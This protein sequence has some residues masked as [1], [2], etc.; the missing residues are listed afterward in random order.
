MPY[1]DKEK[2][3][4]YRKEYQRN[5]Y[6]QNK[7]EVLERRWK[8]RRERELAIRDWFRRYKSELYC[9]ECGEKHPACLQFHHRDRKEKSFTISDAVLRGTSIKTIIKEIEKCDVLCVNCH[10]K[11][12][13]QENHETDSWEEIL[14]EE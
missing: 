14:S 9:V 10:A 1:K 7:D 12:H 4:A 3:A 8:R 5:W 11:R 6:Q 2:A 13:W